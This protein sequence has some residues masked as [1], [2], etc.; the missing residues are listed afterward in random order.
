[1]AMNSVE[2]SISLMV[3]RKARREPEDKALYDASLN[4]ITYATPPFL[5][6]VPQ[7]RSKTRA[8]DDKS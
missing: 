3:P 8:F 7:E 2:D 4:A 6:E 1:M 5:Y